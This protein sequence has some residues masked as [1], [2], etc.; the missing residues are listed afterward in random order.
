MLNLK[1][2]QGEEMTSWIWS[3]SKD[4]RR[5]FLAKTED[6]LHFDFSFA[7]RNKVDFEH[8]GV[9]VVNPWA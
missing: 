7:T 8:T 6:G 3:P 4:R 2:G 5:R 1:G 9:T